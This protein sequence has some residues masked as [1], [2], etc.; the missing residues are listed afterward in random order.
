MAT[1]DDRQENIELPPQVGLHFWHKGNQ[2]DR[3]CKKIIWIFNTQH[4]FF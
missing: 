4:K 2:Y 1:E 3:R